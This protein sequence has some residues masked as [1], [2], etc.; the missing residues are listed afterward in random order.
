MRWQRGRRSD[1]VDD[2]RGQGGGFRPVGLPRGLPGGMPRRGGRTIGGGL[3]LLLILLALVFGVDPSI[4]LQGGGSGSVL[5][6]PVEAPLTAEED[7]LAAFV[8]VVLADTEDTWQALFERAGQRY[9]EPTLVLFSGYTRSACG[10]ASSAMGPFYCP[11]DRQV[12]IDLQFYD[13]LA[14]RLGAPGDFAQAY[15]LA[16]EVGHHVQT[17][18]GITQEVTALRQRSDTVESNRLSVLVELQADCFAG[19]WGHHA[20]ARDLLEPGDLDEAIRAAGAV[21]D[22]TLQRRSQGMVV[23]DSFT[24]GSAEQRIDW[25]R[26]GFD[27]GDPAVCNTFEAAGL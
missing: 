26:R 27:A 14:R 7:E 24:H 10:S 12:Y 17:L 1:N 11:G 5:Q 3:G 23:P 19:V 22:D 9:E 25:F 8:S 21:G 6:A 18:L 2:R 20:A 15:V 4:L 16:H 13:E